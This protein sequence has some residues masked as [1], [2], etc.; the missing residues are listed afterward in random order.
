MSVLFTAVKGLTKLKDLDEK[1]RHS[2]YD[3]EDSINI[4]S[5]K[6]DRNMGEHWY[7][8]SAGLQTN[9]KYGW[10]ELH[11]YS[12]A[13]K[14]FF[15]REHRHR[16]VDILDSK[17]VLENDGDQIGGMPF[18][19][20]LTMSDFQICGPIVSQKLADDFNK[21]H[22]LFEGLGWLGEDELYDWYA[23]Y[24]AMVNFA[25]GDGAFWLRSC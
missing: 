3:D 24:R 16:L 9:S 1:D 21:H 5:G 2:A 23:T 14:P 10:K 12:T 15:E 8:Y 25:A 20:L 22:S 6:P 7:D 4:W 19:E 13:R 17:G 18:K 11:W